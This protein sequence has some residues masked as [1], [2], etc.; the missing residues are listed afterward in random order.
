M[1]FT[2]FVISI[3]LSQYILR[4]ETEVQIIELLHFEQYFRNI[5][6]SDNF[7]YFITLCLR[8]VVN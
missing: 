7:M 1:W 8:I 5:L 3:I 4:S 2:Y 6:K